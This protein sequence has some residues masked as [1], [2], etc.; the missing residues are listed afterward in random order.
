M[1]MLIITYAQA[2]L[3]KRESYQW[4]RGAES[5]S[6]KT[7]YIILRGC[8]SDINVFHLVTTNCHLIQYC[9]LCLFNTDVVYKSDV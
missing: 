2:L 9:Q 8:W 3:Y 4:L 5:V 6:D 7:S 1:G